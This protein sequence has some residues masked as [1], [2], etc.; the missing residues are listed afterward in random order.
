[1]KRRI[2]ALVLCISTLFSVV[3]CG[4]TSQ[5]SKKQSQ[6]SITLNIAYQYGLAYAPLIIVQEQKLIESSFKEATGKDV[7]VTWTKMDSGADI[8]TGFAS[9]SIDVGFMGIGPAITGITKGTGYKIFTNLSGQEHGFMTNDKA[10]TSF[11]DLIGSDEQIALVNVGSIQHIILAKALADSGYDPHELDS[12]IVAMKHPDGMTALET[13]NI[14]CHLTSSPYIYQEREEDNLYELDAINKAWP[15]E[16][17]FIVGVASE[18]LYD[19]NQEL[20]LALCDAISESINYINDNME[21]AAKIT[22]EYNGNSLEDELKYLQA[23]IYTAQTKGVFELATFMAEA[24]FID[25]K[26]ESYSDLTFDNVTG[27]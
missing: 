18:K 26:P 21:E 19:D 9:G 25:S 17:S 10:I 24:D 11:D 27:D 23:G 8:N 15:K 7:T 6:E 1:M 2:L 3:G 22:C 20:Y 4:T 14:A 5:E 12:S 13:G 16:N